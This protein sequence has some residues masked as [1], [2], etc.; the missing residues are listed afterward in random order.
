LR[1]C[2]K[3]KYRDHDYWRHSRY[4]F[5]ADYCTFDEFE[6]I[7]PSLAE[8]LKPKGKA[9]PVFD[10]LYGY[11]KRGNAGHVYRL[12]KMYFFQKPN[13][14]WITHMGAAERKKHVSKIPIQQSRLLEK[15]QK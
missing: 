4:E 6:E 3:C 8:Q 11:F 7:L 10:E 12:E 5:E 2:P 13:G 9:D 15:R 14:K 1:V